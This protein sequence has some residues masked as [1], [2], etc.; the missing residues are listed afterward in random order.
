MASNPDGTGMSIKMVNTTLESLGIADYDVTKDFDISVIDKALEKVSSA[1]S[2]LGA[3]SNAL[4][5]VINSNSYTALNLTSAQIR[6]EDLDYPKAISDLQKERLLEQ[7]KL[8]MIK[9]KSEDESLV[10]RLFR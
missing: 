6:I 2:S 3:S 5:T 9:K 8:N 10:L 1:R 7:Y 4:S